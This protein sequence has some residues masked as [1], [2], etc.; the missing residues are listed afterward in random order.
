MECVL[1]GTGGNG[2]VTVET[3]PD[4]QKLAKVGSSGRLRVAS[5]RLFLIPSACACWAGAT[6]P[7]LWRK[8]PSYSIPGAEVV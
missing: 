8:L 5:T 1:V 2:A 4:A 6:L 7:M 3:G